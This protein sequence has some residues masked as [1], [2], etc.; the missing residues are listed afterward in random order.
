MT[1]SFLQML[2]DGKN[3]PTVTV[4]NPAVGD[5][6]TAPQAGVTEVRL[7]RAQREA[8]IRRALSLA[9]KCEATAKHAR[10]LVA[11]LKELSDEQA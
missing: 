2:G 5:C 10:Q 11:Q 7:S 3:S 8:A 6:R 4:Q 1:V 9:V